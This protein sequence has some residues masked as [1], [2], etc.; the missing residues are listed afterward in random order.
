MLAKLQTKKAQYLEIL[1]HHSSDK[2]QMRPVKLH[3]ELLTVG[4]VGF[5]LYKDGLSIIAALDHAIL[6]L[7]RRT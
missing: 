4:K 5:Y 2:L 1:L 3:T 7:D 6:A